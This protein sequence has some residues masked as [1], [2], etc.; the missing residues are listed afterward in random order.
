MGKL[1]PVAKQS[2][3]DFAR[4]LASALSAE[5]RNSRHAA[6]TMMRWTG[7]SQRSV[8]NWLAGTHTPSSGNLISLAQHS[9]AVR[10]AVLQAIGELPAF[11][12]NRLAAARDIL[13]L[14]I[15]EIEAVQSLLLK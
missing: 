2:D 5:F 13:Y 7:A 14:S 1:L 8:K 6:K 9:P 11:P 10:T 4:E 12:S 3:L 15:S